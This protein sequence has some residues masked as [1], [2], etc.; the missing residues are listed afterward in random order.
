MLQAK[1]ICEIAKDYAKNKTNREKS[2]QYTAESTINRLHYRATVIFLLAFCVLITYF[3]YIEKIS[4]VQAAG[5]T[6]SLNKKHV[7]NTYCF[8]QTTF[9]LP[10]HFKMN[11]EGKD[12]LGIGTHNPKTDE[13]IYHAYYQWVPFV[14][15]LQAMM[16]YF[17]HLLLKNWNSL[18]K[19]KK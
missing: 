15:M 2:L 3:E 5:S 16:F 9:T 7:I 11:Y 18:P 13:R 19:Q 17:P 6:N 14:L 8:I 1:E 10:K 12:F 4:C